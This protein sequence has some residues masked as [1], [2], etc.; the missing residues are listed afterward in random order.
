VNKTQHAP[1]QCVKRKFAYF[2]CVFIRSGFDFSTKIHMHIGK[3]K[4]ANLA[5]PKELTYAFDQ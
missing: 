2:L 3:V 4:N 1:V 5:R